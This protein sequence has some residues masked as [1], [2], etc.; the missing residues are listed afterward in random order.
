[1]SVQQILKSKHIIC[2][3]PDRRKAQAVKDSLEQPVSNKYPSSILQL[4]PDC[5][6]Y[7]DK[8]SAE[9]LSAV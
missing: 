6:F 2:S 9:L 7:F 1:M 4:H 3:V 8:A 5:R